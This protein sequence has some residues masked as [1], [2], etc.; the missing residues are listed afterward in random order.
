MKSFASKILP[1]KPVG[2]SSLRSK[3]EVWI[4]RE[5]DVAALNAEKNR[6]IH[7]SVDGRAAEPHSSSKKSVRKSN[8]DTHRADP[9]LP[10]KSD[11][12]RQ[13]NSP[14]LQES[15]ANNQMNVLIFEQEVVKEQR[16][17]HTGIN[18]LPSQ[19]Q[20]AMIEWSSF[21]KQTIFNQDMGLNEV[22]PHVPQM[23]ILL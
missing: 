19:F 22:R 17:E 1:A 21:I 5:L 20:S 4:Q 16:R 3:S 10:S 11:T 13:N 7:D 14:K 2:T 6:L 12:L 9:K 18:S 23:L 8:A 15:S